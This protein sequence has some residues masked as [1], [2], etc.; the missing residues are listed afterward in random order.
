M[1]GVGSV[2]TLPTADHM[3]ANGTPAPPVFEPPV[4]DAP[5]TNKKRFQFQKAKPQM[6]AYADIP[7]FRVGDDRMTGKARVATPSRA[8][9]RT[10][11][12]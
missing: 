1:P 8:R 6:I 9:L 3:D 10:M 11:H 12:I 2:N 5:Q 7:Q 4:V